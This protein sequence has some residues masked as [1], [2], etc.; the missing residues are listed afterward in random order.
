MTSDK[1]TEANRR[2]ARKST[3]P[4]TPE[5]KAVTR[6][7]ALQH[8][9]LAQDVLL[10]GEDEAALQEL[11]ESLVADLRPEGALEILLVKE[12]IDAHWR[13]RRLRRVETDMFTSQ[14]YWESLER[15]QS[16]AQSY[17]RNFLQDIIENQETAITDEQEHQEALSRAKELQAKQY[18]ETATLGRAFIRDANEANAF[19]RLSRYEAPIWRNLFKAMRELQRIQAARRA[20]MSVTPPAALDVDISGV[21]S[22]D[23]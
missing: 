1:Q 8:G 3:G 22:E 20:N 12:I 9:L 19:S 7:N 6:L 13:L 14:L 2:N 17:E 5:G 18:E 15:A 4:K 21:S 16:K 23:R 10:P 11:G